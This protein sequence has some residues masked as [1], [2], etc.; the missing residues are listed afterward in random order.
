MQQIEIVT[1]LKKEVKSTMSELIKAIDAESMKTD[2]PVFNVGDTVKVG[3]KIIEGGKERIQNFER[4]YSGN[5]HRTPHFLRRRRRKDLSPSL[6]QNRFH[7]GSE[8]G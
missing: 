8:K 4:R 6:A 3:Y 5:F 1:F 7:Y 2:L